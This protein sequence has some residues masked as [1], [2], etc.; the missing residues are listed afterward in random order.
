MSASS[1]NIGTR[2]ECER[3]FYPERNMHQSFVDLNISSWRVLRRS[4]IDALLK[5]N[6]TAIASDSE[7][8]SIARYKNGLLCGY[9]AR[10]VH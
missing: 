2:H 9:L 8:D 1:S 5:L 7:I 6:I 10:S 3:T 4:C